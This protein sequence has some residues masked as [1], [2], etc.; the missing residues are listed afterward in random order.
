MHDF[1]DNGARA[2]GAELR[3]AARRADALLDRG[4][5]AQDQVAARAGEYARAQA[6]WQ[7]RI[8]ARAADSSLPA[9]RCAQVDVS[10]YGVVYVPGGHGAMVDLPDNKPLQQLLAKARA[11]RARVRAALLNPPCLLAAGVVAGR[12][13]GGGVPRPRGAGPR[14]RPRHGRAASARQARVRLY[15]RRRVSVSVRPPR[16]APL[17][18]TRAALRGRGGAVGPGAVG[19]V[20]AGGCGE[21]VGRRARKNHPLVR[22]SAALQL[23]TLPRTVADDAPPQERARGA[24]RSPGDWPEPRVQ[25]APGAGGAGRTARGGGALSR[26]WL[27]TRRAGAAAHMPAHGSPAWAGELGG[28][29]CRRPRG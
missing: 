9:S 21:A 5:H 14:H 18:L 19:A 16:G 7:H 8:C 13:A 27:L 12:G 20:A 6:C 28:D 10:G 15:Q 24:G 1:F 4:V 29:A 3:A 25:R 2:C 23:T 22:A 17:T 11:R 26:C